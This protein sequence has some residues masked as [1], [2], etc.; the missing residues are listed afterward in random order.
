MSLNNKKS[1][2]SLATIMAF[3]VL[4]LFMILP[5]FSAHAMTLPGATLTRIGI[6]LGI[7]GLTQALLQI[8]FGLWSDRIGRKPIIA[9]GLVLFAL[10]SI[11]AALASNIN[12]LIL[13]RALQGTG[14]IGSATLAL[15]ADL[16][17]DESRSKAMAFI[18]LSIGMAFSIAIIIGP[19]IFA[20]Y[21]LS[22]IFWATA[23]SQKKI[24]PAT[25]NQ[26]G[27]PKAF[28]LASM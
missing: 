12:T 8:P 2:L 23:A 16:T 6:A 13:G 26:L 28:R 15:V 22:G 20:W 17:R 3:R 4:G 21:Q 24:A 1:V 25:R 27:G 7:Y 14:A 10:G 19:I 11:V 9:L 5:I 18:G